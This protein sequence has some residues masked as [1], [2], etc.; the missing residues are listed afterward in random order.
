MLYFFVEIINK[1]NVNFEIDYLTLKIVDKKLMTRTTIQETV[2]KPVRAYN[3]V[4]EVTAKKTECI[5]LAIPTFT[6]PADK[7]IV[8]D[9]NEKYNGGRNQKFEI[10]N[11]DLVH[12]REI[13][14][15][16]IK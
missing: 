4:T 13:S 11:E 2:L 14:N 9:L 12:A 7:V 3:Y 16:I 15:F 6:V 5:V 8:F 10:Q 1:S